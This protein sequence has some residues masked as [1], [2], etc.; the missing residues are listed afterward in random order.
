MG[1]SVKIAEFSEMSEEARAEAVHK[2]V[3]GAFAASNGQSGHID[4]QIDEFERE[5]GFDSRHLLKE[6]SEGRLSETDEISDW[7]WLLNFRRDRVS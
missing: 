7:L 5:Y 2:L 1:Y 6:L 3:Q 4:A